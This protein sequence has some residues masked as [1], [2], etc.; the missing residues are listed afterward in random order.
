MQALISREEWEEYLQ[1]KAERRTVEE[2]ALEIALKELK[3]IVQ[4]VRSSGNF[5]PYDSVNVNL[6]LDSMAEGI[7]HDLK[8]RT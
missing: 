7:K 3:D 1:L 4:G 6:F 2:R 5:G 8:P